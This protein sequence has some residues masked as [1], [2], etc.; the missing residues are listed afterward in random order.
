M[1]SRMHQ[2]LLMCL[3]NEEADEAKRKLQSAAKRQEIEEAALPLML[4]AMW[5]ANLMDIDSTVRSVCQKVRRESSSFPSTF[6]SLS[7]TK[8]SPI[9]AFA[10]RLA[11]QIPLLMCKIAFSLLESWFEKQGTEAATKSH[12]V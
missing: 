11:M 5:A 1:K 9:F 2:I 7:C 4:D 10:G 3:Q 12:I 8:T 6:S